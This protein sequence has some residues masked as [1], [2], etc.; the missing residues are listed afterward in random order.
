MEGAT[1]PQPEY[2]YDIEG[3]RGVTLLA[4]LGFH[5]EVPGVGGGFVGPDIFFI[6]SGFVI[7]GQLWKEIAANGTLATRRFYGGRARRLLPVAALVGVVTTICSVILLPPLQIRSVIGDGIA[8]ALYVGN[9]RFALQGVDYFASDRAPSPFQH[10]WT[11]GVEE[12]FYLLWPI[13]LIATAWILRRARRRRGSH[14]GAA[15][16]SKTPYLVLLGLIAVASFAFSLWATQA[17]PPMAY[18]SLPSRAFDLAA[19]CLLALTANQWR[20][21]P[22]LPAAILGWAGLTLI[23][24]VCNQFRSTVP[25]PGTAALLPLLGTVLVLGAG[26]A[27]T[28]HGCGL[29]LAWV[30][31]RAIGRLSY[32]WYLWHWPILLFIPILLDRPMGLADRLASVA[33]SGGLAMLTLHA[34]ENPLRYATSLRR[35]PLRSLAVGAI[36][37]AT[38]VSVGLALLLWVPPPVGHSRARELTIDAGPP[39][40]NGTPQEHDTALQHLITQIQDALTASA[41]IQDVPANLNPPLANIATE[42]QRIFFDGCLRNFLEVGQPECAMGDTTSPTTVALIG[43]SN[44]AMWTPGFQLAATQRH[45]RLEMLAKGRCPMLD[46]PTLIYGRAYTEC[47]QWR[48]E[49]LTRLAREHPKLIVLSIL[50]QYGDPPELQEPFASYDPGWI[51][52]LTRTVRQL[53]TSGAQVLVLGPIPDPHRLQV[54][55]CLSRHLADATLCSLPKST[56]VNEPGIAAEAAAV[57]SGGGDYAD[58]TALFCTAVT[59]PA[60]VGNNLVYFDWMHVTLEYAQLLAPVLGALADRA[61]ARR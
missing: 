10:Y 25:Y 41:D 23:L 11:L 21:L 36:A 3:L 43:D 53:R 59:C 52:A 5:A 40:S 33:I 55:D 17:M 51:D 32:S 28:T 1:A 49:I 6:I 37:T 15:D 30:P 42:L 19:G 27:K 34:V 16:P 57:K 61:L 60:I 39:L 46:L 26:C 48:T 12:Q 24:L 45:W 4:I 54:P 50:R 22:P 20:R 9:Y 31:M 14:R 35:S 47:D 44:A 18:F 7:T 56:A 38:A 13:M 29:V 58:I 8:C 2:R